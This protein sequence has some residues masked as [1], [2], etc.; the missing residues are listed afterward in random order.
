MTGGMVFTVGNLAP[1]G[2]PVQGKI[3]GKHIFDI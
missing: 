1:D 3:L 2:D